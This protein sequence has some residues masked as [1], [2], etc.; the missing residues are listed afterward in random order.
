MTCLQWLQRGCQAA[1][2]GASFLWPVAVSLPAAAGSSEIQAD[3]VQQKKTVAL[4]NG[5]R[6]KYVEMGKSD[7]PALIL[8]HG[9][10]DNSRSWSL[11]AP[12]LRD[13]FHIFAVD[14]RGQGQTTAPDC[15]YTLSDMAFDVKLF[16]DAVGL[17][18]ADIVGHS[19]G[20]MITQVFAETYPDRVNRVILISSTTSASKAAARDGWLWQNVQQLHDP[21]DPNSQFIKDW[22]TNPNPVDAEFLK[23]EMSESAAVPVHVWRQIARNL[24][25]DEFGRNLP[26]LHAPVLILWGSA[27]GFFDADA[28]KTLRAALPQAK[29]VRFENVG[30]NIMWEQPEN[31]AQEILSF[32]N[33]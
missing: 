4:P 9:F 17:K 26:D 32:L 14:Q 19:L 12:Y 20:S 24:S 13:R 8:L 22:Y 29:F 16:M 23:H 3:W 2:I 7:Q 15:C 10:T 33:N 25:T 21:I 1:L 27:D 30:H 31:V 11:L 28:Q 6:M 18:K 5:I